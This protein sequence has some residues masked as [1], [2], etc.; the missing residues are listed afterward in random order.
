MAVFFA[1]FRS[2]TSTNPTPGTT[3]TNKKLTDHPSDDATANFSTKASDEVSASSSC[4]PSQQQ[5]GSTLPSPPDAEPDRWVQAPYVDPETAPILDEKGQ[6]IVSKG[7]WRTGEVAYRT[8]PPPDSLSPRFGYNVLQVKKDVS[9]WKHYH[10]YPRFSLAH[11]N[12]QFLFLIGA[13][14]VVAFLMTEY[15][16]MTDEM[17]TPGA[18]V[19]EHRGRGPSTKGTQ[20]VTFTDDEM[21]VLLTGAQNNWLDAKSEKGYLGSKDYR[22]KQIARPQEMTLDDIRKR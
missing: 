21:N 18:M 20:K 12:I 7:K 6:F 5:E 14:W 11:L 3:D 8:P 4:A 2:A 19:G 17:R 9:W 16:S 10:K 15:R 1:P 13:A 22:M